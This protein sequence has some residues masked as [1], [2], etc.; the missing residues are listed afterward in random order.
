MQVLKLIEL[1]IAKFHSYEVGC[2]SRTEILHYKKIV[3]SQRFFPDA[4]TNRRNR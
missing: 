1:E 4:F 3:L 2:V